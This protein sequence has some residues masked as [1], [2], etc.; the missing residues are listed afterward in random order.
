MA[1]EIQSLRI[2]QIT[3]SPYTFQLAN[4]LSILNNSTDDLLITEAGQTAP[5]LI[6]KAGQSVSLNSASGFVLPD[7]TLTCVSMDASIVLT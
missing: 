5:P 2:E 1:T 4:S 3:T 7:I 6:L